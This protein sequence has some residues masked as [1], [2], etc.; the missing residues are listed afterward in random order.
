MGGRVS[1]REAG[2]LTGM[3][4]LSQGGQAAH[5][6][7]GLLQGGPASDREAGPLTGRPGLS[8][9]GWASSRESYCIF[10]FFPLVLAKLLSPIAIL[11]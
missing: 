3:L 7:A 6:E 11:L 5:R 8:Q 2:P 1:H 10:Q 4:A 9:G